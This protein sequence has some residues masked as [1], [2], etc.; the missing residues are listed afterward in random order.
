MTSRDA[1]LHEEELV[2]PEK[3]RTGEGDDPMGAEKL[4]T[5]A[6]LRTLRGVGKTVIQLNR[7][8]L[9]LNGKNMNLSVNKSSSKVQTGTVQG[10]G[11]EKPT[12][13]KSTGD[14]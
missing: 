6:N 8:K 5:S 12:K 9:L 4:V 10:R 14:E 13:P 7:T 11:N 3:A 2:V 1:S